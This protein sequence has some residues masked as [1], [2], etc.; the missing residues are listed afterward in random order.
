MSD[1]EAL[2]Y[3]YSFPELQRQFGY[4]PSS[5]KSVHR[6]WAKEG[7]NIPEHEKAM[8]ETEK[9]AYKLGKGANGTGKCI[10]TLWMGAT[11]R[12]DNGKDIETWEDMRLFKTLT[13]ET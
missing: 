6:F 7:W 5:I 11:K 8:K 9:K 1:Y 3:L 10:G 13:K 4:G 2:T 12:P